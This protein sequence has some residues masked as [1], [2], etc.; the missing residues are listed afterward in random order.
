MFF[1]RDGHVKI[2]TL[3]TG[4]SISSFSTHIYHQ[5]N[6]LA[7][8]LLHISTIDQFKHRFSK[9]YTQIFGHK[10]NKPPSSHA[11]EST[12]LQKSQPTWRNNTIK[13]M[14]RKPIKEHTHTFFFV[15]VG[16]RKSDK[17]H[18]EKTIKSLS[19]IK[20]KKTYRLMIFPPKIQSRHR[21]K[22]K[23][24]QTRLSSH[25]HT[26]TTSLTY[27]WNPPPNNQSL[28]LYTYADHW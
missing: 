20:W 24:N 6:C 27:T 11:Y 13:S 3:P 2:W 19:C 21:K 5:Q 18:L 9:I 10:H 23:E 28:Q 17:A 26:S 25:Y 1:Q 16:F 7:P 22:E 12:C 8:W 15:H 4:T 14:H